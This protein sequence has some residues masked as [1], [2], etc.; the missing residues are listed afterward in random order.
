MYQVLELCYKTSDNAGLKQVKGT[1]T[2]RIKI[3]IKFGVRSACS[4]QK[5]AQKL[6]LD[7]QLTCNEV[8]S[9]RSGS[10]QAVLDQDLPP[11]DGVIIARL[12]L[13]HALRTQK[14]CA[15]QIQCACSPENM[16]NKHCL[17]SK[18][19]S[20]VQEDRWLRWRVAH[21]GT[22][23]PN[24]HGGA[25]LHRKPKLQT[26]L[27]ADSALT[28]LWFYRTVVLSWQWMPVSTSWGCA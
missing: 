2:C 9:Q 17:A 1:G 5:Q 18:S 11:H 12:H 13:T 27:C 14:A 19:G 28:G 7:G 10:L 3:G 16:S 4:E 15:V 20:A 8:S 21:S 6:I 24:Q 22:N 23:R 26:L 25:A